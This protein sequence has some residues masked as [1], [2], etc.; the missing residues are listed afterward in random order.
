MKVCL[1]GN[2]FKPEVP[3]L[4]ERLR[5]WIEER[6]EI[7]NVVL[8]PDRPFDPAG[9]D[10]CI[11]F[12]GDG[13]ILS[14][15]RKLTTFEV[16]LVGINVGH[17]GFLASIHPEEARREL[18][19]IFAGEYTVSERMMLEVE[20]LEGAASSASGIMAALNDVVFE[21]GASPRTLSIEVRHGGEYFNTTTADGL[22]IATPT[23]STAY[24]LSAGGPL[25][26]PEMELMIITPICPHCL[27]ERPFIVSADEPVTVRVERPS[28][29]EMITLDGQ[30][31]YRPGS[32]VEITVRKSSSTFKLLKP[33]ETGQYDVLRSKLNWGCPF[34][35][36]SKDNTEKTEE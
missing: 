24:S 30:V 18:E 15:A 5:P 23:G 9:A 2:P 6:A 26:A 31:V 3:R 29:D 34:V 22:I 11:V 36:V 10:A 20:G 1:F 28:G 12:G 17:L 35:P 25:V 14:C 16:P 33:P 4:V 8:E 32:E 19:R 27:Y 13:T 7:T 21:R